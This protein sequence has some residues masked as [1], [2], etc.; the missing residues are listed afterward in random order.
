MDIDRQPGISFDAVL[1]RYALFEERE[2][3]SPER[4]EGLNLSFSSKSRMLGEGVERGEVILSVTVEPEGD[5]PPFRVQVSVSGLFG[6][7][8]GTDR[9]LEL[10]EFLAQ[11]AVALLLPYVR[12]AVTNLTART[13]FGPVIIP[14]VNVRAMLAEARPDELGPPVGVRD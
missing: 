6:Y 4:Q 14:P 3:P 11:Q 12:E 13:A 7:Q 5:N 2:P 10:E 8:I 9:N 1:L